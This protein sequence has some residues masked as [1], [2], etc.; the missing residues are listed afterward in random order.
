MVKFKVFEADVWSDCDGF[1]VNQYY[2]IIEIYTDKQLII[3]L[4]DDADDTTIINSLINDNIIDNNILNQDD[5]TIDIDYLYSDIIISIYD[6]ND[7]ESLPA[8]I[9]LEELQS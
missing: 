7:I 6:N 3:A 8:I 9:K 1:S 2:P 5:Y 4:S